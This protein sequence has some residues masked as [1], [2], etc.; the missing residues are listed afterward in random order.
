MILKIGDTV[1]ERTPTEDFTSKE[2]KGFLSAL[3]QL[4]EEDLAQNQ[5]ALTELSNLGED[6]EG[7]SLGLIAIVESVERESGNDFVKMNCGL[8]ATIEAKYDGTAPYFVNQ[9][10]KVKVDVPFSVCT[11]G[12]KTDEYINSK[13]QTNNEQ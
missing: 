1:I 7:I 5:K 8:G 3:N 11:I 2:S 10:A 6:I 12:F 4:T 9:G 13:I